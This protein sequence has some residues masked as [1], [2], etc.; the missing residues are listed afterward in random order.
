MSRFAHQS[1]DV[2]IVVPCTVNF[3][4]GGRGFDEPLIDP[5]G[6]QAQFAPASDPRGSESFGV[7]LAVD[8]LYAAASALSRVLNREFSEPEWIAL[9]NLMRRAWQ[10]PVIEYRLAALQREYGEH[11]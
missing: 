7:D 9:G 2:T 8:R 10:I 5:L 6:Q 4:V 3:A 11:G 1:A